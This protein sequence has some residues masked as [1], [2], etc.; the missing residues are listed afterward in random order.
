[1][2]RGGSENLSGSELPHAMPAR[3]PAR[4]RVLGDLCAE[5]LPDTDRVRATRGGRRKCSAALPQSGSGRSAA[6]GTGEEAGGKETG[7]RCTALASGSTAT[8][9][10]RRATERTIGRARA[11]PGGLG[12]SGIGALRNRLSMGIALVAVA[13]HSRRI[14]LRS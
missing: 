13:L 2:A 6:V 9:G 7:T 11:C 5:R 8:D 14:C 4:Q 3:G 10:L 1:T 12:A